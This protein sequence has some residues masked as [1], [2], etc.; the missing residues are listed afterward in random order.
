M[1]RN[2]QGKRI[3]DLVWQNDTVY[4]ET[5]HKGKIT[6]IPLLDELY[7]IYAALKPHEKVRML[8]IVTSL[9]QQELLIT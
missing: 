9:A 4:L 3:F 8:E 7:K 6:Q 1:I 2:S 5:Y